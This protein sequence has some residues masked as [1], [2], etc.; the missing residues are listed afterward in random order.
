MKAAILSVAA[1]FYVTACDAKTGNAS[2]CVFSKTSSYVIYRCDNDRLWIIETTRQL[3]AYLA[4]PPVTTLREKSNATPE[5]SLLFNGGYHDGN[6]ANAKLEGLFV[7]DGKPFNAVK[8]EDV[9]LS[10]VLSINRDGR[11]A[12]I[13]VASREF[14]S[15]T[16]SEPTHIQSGPLIAEDG[17]I[18]EAFIAASLNGKDAYKRTAIG[19]THAGE[20]VIVVSKTPRTLKRLG[21]YVLQVN[22]YAK[23]G[24]TLL[25]LDGGPSTAIHSNITNDLSYGADKVTP[26]GFA[27]R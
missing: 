18:A 9:Q 23:R 4:T 10:H 22:R 26:V 12:S 19:R 2:D 24:L 3:V 17:R 5:F 20:T 8:L 15:S 25:N 27:L 16:L 13:R 21:V 1:F 7:V 14:A 11:I 6:Y